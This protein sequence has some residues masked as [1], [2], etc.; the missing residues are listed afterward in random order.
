MVGFATCEVDAMEPD[1]TLSDDGDG[2]LLGRILPM[3]FGLVVAGA[4]AWWLVGQPVKAGLD[5]V[6]LGACQG[7]KAAGSQQEQAGNRARDT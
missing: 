1:K 5:E 6:H 2:G 3:A 7:R 4:L